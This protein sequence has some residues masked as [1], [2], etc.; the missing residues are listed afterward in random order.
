MQAGNF[1]AHRG[2]R[3]HY[4]ENTLIAFEQAIQAGAINI[5]LD[6]QLSADHVPFAFHDAELKRMCQREGLIWEYNA[7]ELDTFH[8][9]EQL[10]FGE[11]FAK[12]PMCRLSDIV[13]LLELN[14]NVNAY[15]EIKEE[16]LTQFGE[17]IVV[18]AI[19]NA[20]RPVASRCVLISFELQ[21]LHLALH[22]G[23]ERFGAVFDTWPDWQSA[24]LA[25]L[26]PE[27]VFCDRNCV[28][29][30]CK[31]AT[32]PWPILIYE[33][34]NKTEAEDWFSRG[35]IAVETFLIGELLTEFSLSPS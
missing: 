9:S 33:V 4:P 7:S 17:H 29:P 6:I 19:I 23:W 24:A 31:L 1:V 8:A 15:V 20:L 21:A 28:P 18:N 10:R 16:S 3:Q 27:V 13:A 2:W 30:D 32:L 34:G 14:P 26:Q 25:E 11:T 12:N 5:E 35:A 22:E